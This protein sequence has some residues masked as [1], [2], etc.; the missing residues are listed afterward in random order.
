MTCE[1]AQHLVTPYI[2]RELDGEQ[3]GE[4]LNHVDHC[5]ECREE[6]EIYYLVNVGLEQLDRD[7]DSFGTFDIVGRLKKRLAESRTHIRRLHRVETA[8][9]AVETVAGIALMVVVALQLRIWLF[10]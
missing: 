3:L 10:P 8:A 1:E 4:F 7:D 2:R 5:P 9:Y 6:L